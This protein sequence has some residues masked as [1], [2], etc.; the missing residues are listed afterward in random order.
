[1]VLIPVAS[2]EQHGTHLPIG[3]DYLNG[4]QQAIQEVANDRP[5]ILVGYS[6]GGVLATALAARMERVKGLL[7]IAANLDVLAWTN[8]HGYAQEIARRSIPSPLPL[9][10]TLTQ[11]HVYGR[12]DVAVPY[13]LNAALLSKEPRA[14]V[15]HIETANHDCCW[16]QQWPQ[17][18][19]VF[20][21]LMEADS[22]TG[23]SLAAPSPL[24]LSAQTGTRSSLS[25]RKRDMLLMS[26]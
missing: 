2:L 22:I 17:I 16:R 6:G 23:A 25:T 21:Q 5:L 24:E 4:L 7:T 8:H 9:V 26:R 15:M 3:T 13:A 19:A 10:K 18:L 11:L 14:Q 20:Q 1:M 12:A